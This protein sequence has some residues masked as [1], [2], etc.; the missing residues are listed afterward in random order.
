MW[1]EESIPGHKPTLPHAG[2]EIRVGNSKTREK[3][4]LANRRVFY[5]HGKR[6]GFQE[7]TPP[8]P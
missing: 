4:L 8:A 7:S 1:Q 6:K 3:K 5:S 2:D